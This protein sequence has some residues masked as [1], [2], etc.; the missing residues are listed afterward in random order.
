MKYRYCSSRGLMTDFV[1][2]D[3]GR[4]LVEPKLR[5]YLLIVGPLWLGYSSRGQIYGNAKAW[6]IDWYR[7]GGE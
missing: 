7:S 2:G 5:V 6:L 3:T 1:V 4:S